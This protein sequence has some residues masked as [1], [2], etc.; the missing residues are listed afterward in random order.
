MINLMSSR[1]IFATVVT[2]FVGLLGSSAIAFQEYPVAEAPRPVDLD[3]ALVNP[4]QAD[5]YPQIDEDLQVLMRGPMHEAFAESYLADPVPSPMIQQAP[6]ADIAEL[7]PEY[8]PDGNNVQW[9]PGYWAW[10]PSRDDF[11]WISGVWRDVPPNRQW[12]SG[13]WESSAE[14]YRWISGFWADESFQEPEYLPAPPP[15]LESGPSS[16]PI[17]ENYFYVPGNWE[18]EVNQYRWRTGHWMPCTQNWIWIPARYVWTPRGFIYRCGYWDFDFVRRG[19]IL[20]PSVLIGRY[21][22]DP[23]TAT[24]PALFLGLIWDSWPTCLFV[25]TA[26]NIILAI[27]TDNRAWAISLGQCPKAITGITT[28]C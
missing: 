26:T 15:S 16:Q 23:V 11:I 10:D 24:P 6:P 4:N 28:H 9:I 14:G 27:G 18:Y 1:L 22:S 8:K 2:S 19:A 12:V 20:R 21:I 3:D 5:A 13:Y 17:G 7:P 25:E